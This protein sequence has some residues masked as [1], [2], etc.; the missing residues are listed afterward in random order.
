MLD[1]Q[2]F[3]FQ[4]ALPKPKVHMQFFLRFVLIV[5]GSSC[6][7]SRFVSTPNS[8]SVDEFVLEHNQEI[9]GVVNVG[10]L[11]VPI[12]TTV[13]IVGE[14][15]IMC[16]EMY[17]DGNLILRDAVD[18][19]PIRVDAPGLIITASEVFQMKGNIYGGAGRSFGQI[20]VQIG[21]GQ[22]GGDGS[23]ITITSP[24]LMLVGCVKGGD[25]GSAGCGA[26]GGD[27]GNVVTF[28][29]P[30]ST[31]GLT[32]QELEIRSTV[33][34]LTGGSG[35]DVYLG[36]WVG[37]ANPEFRGGNSGDAFALPL[38]GQGAGGVGGDQ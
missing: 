15:E 4:F 38:E 18:M 32:E 23:H 25:G 30:Q 19:I 28:G 34:Q 14:T 27:G 26:R 5:M 9:S 11:R 17:L 21:F 36:Q 1:C 20:P 3:L 16:T 6:A 13:W 35:G 29:E 33:Y 2:E 31:H 8:K 37:Q 10:I 12:D 24:D 22:R 7:N